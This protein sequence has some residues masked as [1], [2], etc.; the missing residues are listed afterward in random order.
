MSDPI[1]LEEYPVDGIEFEELVASH[2]QSKGLYVERNIIER[3]IEE[4]L[5]LDIITT[6]YNDQLPTTSIYEVK[7][8]NWGFNEIFK[9]KGW[10]S[11]I[12]QDSACLIVKQSRS[13][14]DFYYEKCHSL[15]INLNIFEDEKSISN[16]FSLSGDKLPDIIWWR[17]SYLLERKLISALKKWKRENRDKIC[18]EVADKY[19]QKIKGGIFF[20]ENILERIDALYDLY[21]K[22][23]NL[24]G[25]TANE[26][27]TGDFSDNEIP[28]AIFSDTFYKCKIN[29]LQVTTYIEYLSRLTILKNAVDFIQ[30]EKAGETDKTDKI[31]LQIEEWKLTLLDF[32]PSSFKD[33]IKSIQNEPYFHL[34]PIFWQWFIFLFGGFILTDRVQEEYKLLS[35]CTGIPIDQIPNALSVFD[36]LFPVP[37]GWFATQSTHSIKLLKT[38]PMSFRGIGANYRLAA[39]KV[40]NYSNLKLTGKFTES[41]LGMWHNLGYNMI[42]KF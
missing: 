12:K 33:G 8:G 1:K 37:G 39:Y 10:L 14:N 5:E 2:F 18:F 34:Y 9:L 13:N 26:L 41:D 11:Y 17:Y 27:S 20:T 38:F 16:Y 15:G 25:R 30:Y 31:I 36:K 28:S 7:S 23:H 22:N 19:H 4:V 24:S 35:N 21:K 29:P 42:R 6:N 40:D 3:D 32:I